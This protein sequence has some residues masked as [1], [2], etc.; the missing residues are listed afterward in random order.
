MGFE[1]H[2]LCTAYKLN[3][4]RNS[5]LEGNISVVD[6]IKRETLYVRVMLER[7]FIKNFGWESTRNQRAKKT[8]GW[9]GR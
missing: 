6:E 4:H 8:C 1:A 7:K 2:N 9:I 3:F 5:Y